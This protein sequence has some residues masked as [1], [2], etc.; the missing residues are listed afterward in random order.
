MKQFGTIFSFEWKQ[1][2]RNKVFVGVTLFLVVLIFAV[3]FFPRLSET[4][5][6]EPSAAEDRPILW[7]AGEPAEAVKDLFTQA[8]ADYTVRVT[9][10]V[11]GIRTQIAEGQA[12]CAFVFDDVTHYTYYVNNL[13]MYDQNTAIADEVMKT[14]YRQNALMQSGLSAEQA[15]RI[16]STPIE[17]RTESLGKSQMQYFFYTYIMVIALYMMILLYGQMVATNVASE[18]SSRAMELLVTSA[19]PTAMMFGK[20]LSSCFAGLLQMVL[21]F[22]TSFVCYRLNEP[23]WQDNTIVASIF[24]MPLEL[25]LYM[26]LFF[27]L[28]FLVYAFLYAAIGS[29]VSKMEDVNTAVMPVTMLFVVALFVVIFSMTG[30]DVD[31]LLM[32][33]CSLVPFTSPVAMFTRIAMS[34]VPIHEIVW[35]IVLL[36]GAVIGV[37]VLAARIYR[38][39]VL[40]YGTR[41][42]I[43]ALLRAVFHKA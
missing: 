24:N 9:D 7:I 6:K 14:V 11:D 39:G 31:T 12:A 4:L 5:Q 36:V 40:L 16:L 1:Y 20:V 21:V 29:T 15:A 13:T 37:G 22:G 35:S 10:D 33:V 32:R 38:V 25:L 42:K 34:T 23:Y 2:L 28:G 19:K 27:L 3:M 43:G 8:F 18:K 30:G 26:L 41:P 17:H